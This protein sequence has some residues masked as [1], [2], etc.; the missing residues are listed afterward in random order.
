[1][2]NYVK[3]LGIIAFVALIGFLVLGCD[4]NNDDLEKLNGDW[5]RTGQ[6]VV[7]FKD[8]KGTFK[9]LYGG[10]WLDG[11]NAGQINIGE[12]CYRNFAKSGDNKWTAEIRIY[13]T[14][15]PHETLRWENCTM[16]LSTN[17]QTLQ[18]LSNV[19]T[20]DLTKK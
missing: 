20:F 8:G 19:G 13:N 18:V 17:S 2:K 12:Q 7:T 1:M 11:K 6:Y 15:S 16:T 14:Y 5:D 10:I 4:L 3:R 9:D